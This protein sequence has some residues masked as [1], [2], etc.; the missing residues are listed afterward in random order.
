MFDKVPF[1]EKIFD[2]VVRDITKNITSANITTSDLNNIE[3]KLKREI[4]SKSY[5]ISDLVIV[6]TSIK[7]NMS[8][9][10][11]TKNDVQV[12]AKEVKRLKATEE[13]SKNPFASL[14][15]LSIMDKFIA[16]FTIIFKTIIGIVDDFIVLLVSIFIILNLF[17]RS[18]VDSA[19]LYPNNPN[20][21][22]YVFFDKFGNTKQTFLTSSV[23]TN[24][25]DSEDD[26]FLDT[27]A[28][29][30]S[31]GKYDTKKNVCKIND[32]YGVTMEGENNLCDK[33]IATDVDLKDFMNPITYE[34][35]NFFARKFMETNS[36]KT[37]NDLSLYGML[38]FVMLTININA[39]GSMQSV[40]SFFSSMFKKKPGES[41]SLH[42]ILFVFFTFVFYNM[43]QNTKYSFANLFAKL[44]PFRS[45]MES[46]NAE[47][48]DSF[49]K[50]ISGLFSPFMVFFKFFFLFVYPLILFHSTFAYVN[51]SIY[52]SGLFVKLF[53]YLGVAFSLMM[54][55]THFGLMI[56]SI[57]KK[58]VTIDAIFANIIKEF[59]QLI[60]VGVR[61][62]TSILP[63]KNLEGMTSGLPSICN[64]KEMFGFS[65]IGNILRSIGMMF[66]TPIII[67]LFTMPTF[68]T[69]YMTF[70][71]TKSV[72][73][74]FFKY[75]KILI[76]EMKQ[77]QNI[78][79]AFFWIIV[80]REITQYMDKPMKVI[81]IGILICILGYDAVKNILKK[82]LQENKCFPETN[83]N[84]NNNVNIN[85]QLS[86]LIMTNINTTNNE[87][88][89]STTGGLV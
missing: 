1:D 76:C 85:E 44:F 26:V 4:D 73:L 78:I 28:F 3:K 29:F 72:T 58:N 41:T 71:I 53:C 57:Q 30:T 46:K 38:C 86:D 50:L 55:L 84:N 7:D 80:I 48:V 32:P 83:N 65:F 10:I 62:L 5:T 70:D 33:K 17:F 82:T 54:F 68:V 47:V 43:F 2:A 63:K 67:I 59:I 75:I 37:T 56:H 64:F 18:N 25:K 79:R 60:N 51:Y 49:V 31:D 27:P 22:P 52:A 24:L 35:L 20:A 12:V 13:V 16:V 14:E 21:Y 87:K 89:S 8:K 66:L 39:N 34:N 6:I 15:G 42:S 36:E 23:E 9:R 61:K 81:T 40:D 69:L 77:F 19:I 88:N 45:S 74:D 11:F